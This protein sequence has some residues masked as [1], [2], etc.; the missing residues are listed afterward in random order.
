MIAGVILGEETAIVLLCKRDDFLGR[1]IDEEDF[2]LS[3]GFPLM[4]MCIGA[5]LRLMAGG[6]ADTGDPDVGE[7]SPE[8]ASR[9][10]RVRCSS[11][12]NLK[13]KFR[14][15]HFPMFTSERGNQYGKKTGS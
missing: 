13:N 4:S 7:S 11:W 9:F 3:I 1:S 5:E 12:R 2:F 6:E 8:V 10:R 15:T 14:N